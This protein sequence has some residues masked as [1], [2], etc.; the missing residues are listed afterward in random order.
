MRVLCLHGAQQTA[1]IF[2]TK[3]GNLVPKLRRLAELDFVDGPHELA[4]REGD[5]LPTRVWFLRDEERRIDAASLEQSLMLLETLWRQREYAGII[6]F[7]QGGSLAAILA[8]KPVLF[9][10]LSFVIVAG[11]PDI[12]DLRIP[13]SVR[14]MHLIGSR[15]EAVTSAS[16]LALSQRFTD[17]VV[18]DHELGHVIPS[19]AEF[20]RMYVDFVERSLPKETS[21][22]THEENY[23]YLCSSDDIATAQREEAE[24]LSSIYPSEI[25]VLTSP[26]QSAGDP[27][28]AFRLRIPN[29]TS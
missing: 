6:G 16:S 22:N 3:L 20:L 26:P 29:S 18:I 7:S 27:C 14:S 1:E 23:M 28:A 12:P 24:V 2:R 4:V 13:S 19:R 5:D 25:E 8:S 21:S 17:P 11:A 10:G 15:D 9:P